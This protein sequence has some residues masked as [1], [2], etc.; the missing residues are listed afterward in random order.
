MKNL[1]RKT[2]TLAVILLLV[3]T[4]SAGVVSAAGFVNIGN[5]RNRVTFFALVNQWE[6]LQTEK[7]QFHDLLNDYGFDVPELSVGQKRQIIRTIIVLRKQGAERE[8]IRDAVVDL[9]IGYGVNL[10]DLTS[11]QRGEIRN[12]TKNFLEQDY[13]FVFVELTE[14]QQQEIRQTV[15]QMKNEYASREQIKQAVIDLYV[16]YGGVIPELSDS[17][18]EEIYDWMVV[19]LEDDYGVEVPELSFEQRQII[20]QESNDIAS[21][22]NELRQMFNNARFFVKLRFIGYLRRTIE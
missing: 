1:V 21:L 20:R 16:S 8:E 5:N 12:Q 9:L 10:P 13:G 3:G 15:K 19:L 22:R 2:A 4:L 14:D 17:E 7:Q 18:R 11:E 6:T